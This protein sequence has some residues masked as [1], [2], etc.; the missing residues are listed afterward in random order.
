M[1]SWDK[2]LGKVKFEGLQKNT[3]KFNKLNMHILSG[4]QGK[5]K[6]ILQSYNSLFKE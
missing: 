5:W 6:L 2:F 3:V 1:N 4:G